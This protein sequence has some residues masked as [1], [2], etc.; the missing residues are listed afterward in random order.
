MD[1]RY[2]GRTIHLARQNKQ[3]TQG[4]LAEQ[5]GLTPNRVSR[6]D[7]GLLT[8]SVETLCDICNALGT[9]ADSILAA[10]IQADTARRW[11]PTNE[12]IQQLPMDK[13]TIVQNVLECLLDNLI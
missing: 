1:F 13:Q 5:T 10:Y 9:D 2:G 11:A 12:R 8:P 4:Q 6:S 7:R 3:L